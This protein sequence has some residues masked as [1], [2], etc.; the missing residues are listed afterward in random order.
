[1]IKSLISKK[2]ASLLIITLLSSFYLHTSHAATTASVNT[3]IAIL[4][5]SKKIALLELEIKL[6]KIQQ[7]KAEVMSRK[8]LAMDV[9]QDTVS[10]MTRLDSRKKSK[11]NFFVPAGW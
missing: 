2:S 10:T 3:D 9:R 7:Q 1:M 6:I 4:E 8:I 5:L 11:V